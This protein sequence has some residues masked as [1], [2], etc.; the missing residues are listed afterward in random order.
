MYK[1][2]L[3]E[4]EI[5]VLTGTLGPQVARGEREIMALMVGLVPLVHLVYLGPQP[6]EHVCL[7]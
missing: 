3:E 5:E 4:G 2:Y 6:R 1:A 7:V